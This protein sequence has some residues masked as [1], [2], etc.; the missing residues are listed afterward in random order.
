MAGNTLCHLP[1]TSPHRRRPA[2][3]RPICHTPGTAIIYPAQQ[4]SQMSRG[5]LAGQNQSPQPSAGTD[6]AGPP[7]SA[8]S[9]PKRAMVPQIPTPTITFTPSS[10]PQRGS[11]DPATRRRAP[12]LH[13]AAAVPPAPQQAA[14]EQ[15][16]SPLHISRRWQSPRSF[17]FITPAASNTHPGMQALP[18][19]G[20]RRHLL[21]PHPLQLHLHQQQAAQKSQPSGHGRRWTWQHPQ[22]SARPA[23]LHQ[24][25]GRLVF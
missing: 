14:A 7:W 18:A 9:P 17:T 5:I 2:I 6:Y 25:P 19:Q 23:H 22:W 3:H 20:G 13:Q 1:S 4:Q 16:H 10:T 15:R 8:P 24:Q 21:H 11:N 12:V